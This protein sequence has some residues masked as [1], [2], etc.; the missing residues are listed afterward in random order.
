MAA[1]Y[2]S[3]AHTQYSTSVTGGTTPT[4][5][6]IRDVPDW[7]KK[8]QR[9]DTPAL[10]LIDRASAPEIPML[11]REWGWGDPDPFKDRITAAYTAGAGSLTVADGTKF[12]VGDL[13]SGDDVLF[14]VTAVSGNTL[15]VTAGFGDS[16]DANIADESTIYILAPATEENDDDPSSVITQGQV[17]HNFHQIM[18]WTWRFSHRAQVTPTYESR[19]FSGD[20]FQQELR[21]KMEETAPLK[22]ELNLLRSF[23]NQGDAG[24]D[25]NNPSTFGG[26]KQSSYITTRTDLSG[27]PL[28]EFDFH[29]NLQTVWE[30]VGSSNIGKTVMCSPFTARIISSWYNPS[31]RTT[32]TEEKISVKFT[33]VEDWFGEFRIVPNWLM[34]DDRLYVF[35]GDDIDLCPYHS[36]TGWQTGLIGPNQE[37]WYRIGFLRGDYTTVWQMPDSRLEISGFSTTNTDYPALV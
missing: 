36:S 23:R 12:A 31:R 4:D 18:S 30:I 7:T 29:D 8:Q 1:T 10:K 28:T 15:T 24:G 11:K 9:T 33:R 3:A 26:F 5:L 25:G 34:D 37:G 17:D 6:F 14:H 32:G 35:N 27:A 19:N 2:S 21:K 13:V 20:R 16:T 22:L